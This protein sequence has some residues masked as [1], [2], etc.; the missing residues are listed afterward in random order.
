M[1][2]QYEVHQMNRYKGRAGAFWHQTEMVIP[3]SRLERVPFSILLLT[4][5]ILLLLLLLLSELE[6]VQDREEGET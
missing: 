4:Y 6:K 2:S 3:C 5:G 1:Y